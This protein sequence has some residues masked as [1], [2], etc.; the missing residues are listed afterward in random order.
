MATLKSALWQIR[1]NKLEPYSRCCNWI[2]RHGIPT[3]SACDSTSKHRH[4]L[5]FQ[6]VVWR[7]SRML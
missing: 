4:L 5:V 7:L 3:L 6:E 1:Q 2:L